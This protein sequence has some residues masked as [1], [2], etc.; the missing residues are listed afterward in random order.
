MTLPKPPRL[1]NPLH[2]YLP[3]PKTK[4]LLLCCCGCGWTELFVNVVYLFFVYEDEY[5]PRDTVSLQ[6]CLLNTVGVFVCCMSVI[7]VS[8]CH[9]NTASFWWHCSVVAQHIKT[10]SYS[11]CFYTEFC[12]FLGFV[13]LSMILLSTLELFSIDVFISLLCSL[14]WS[15]V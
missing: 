8:R 3:R 1:A 10:I 7:T 13:L 15:T 4:C 6:Y 14:L 5:N 9:G 2:S 11:R 12:W